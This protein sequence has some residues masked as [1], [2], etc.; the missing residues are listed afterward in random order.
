YYVR[1]IPT[2]IVS[3]EQMAMQIADANSIT[4]ADIR[5]VWE[6]IISLVI[7]TLRYGN[8][9]ELSELG[10]FSLKI[11]STSPIKDNHKILN[12][13]IKFNGISFTPSAYLLKSMKGLDF[14]K[15]ST[16]PTSDFSGAQRQEQIMSLFLKNR[17]IYTKQCSQINNCSNSTSTSDLKS[18]VKQKL[19]EKTGSGNRVLYC[20][21]ARSM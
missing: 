2:E 17:F 10:T 20:L 14:Q 6:A 16:H 7:K 13:Q 12:S 1:H 8:R 15:K 18:L 5:A 19:I 21:P 9:V 4:Y 3:L 11:K